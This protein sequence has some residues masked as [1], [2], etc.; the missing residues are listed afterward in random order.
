MVKCTNKGNLCGST[1]TERF[2]MI[3]CQLLRRV[4]HTKRNSLNPLYQNHYTK[5]RE[6]LQLCVIFIFLYN[7][8]SI[9]G[10]HAYLSVTFSSNIFQMCRRSF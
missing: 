10:F 3:I 1:T 2:F 9:K 6:A 4:I 7:L 5:K 8:S